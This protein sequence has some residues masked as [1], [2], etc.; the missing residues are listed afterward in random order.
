MPGNRPADIKV[1]IF[2][3]GIAGM[4]VAHELIERGFKV[5]LVDKEKNEVLEGAD[6]VVPIRCGGMAAT[7][8]CY[9][10]RGDGIPTNIPL[11]R[12]YSS[13]EL[14]LRPRV[15]FDPDSVQPRD[16]GEITTKVNAVIEELL[17][18]FPRLVVPHAHAPRHFPTV[19]TSGHD[20]RGDVNR[21]EKRAM[22][23]AKALDEAGVASDFMVSQRNLTDGDYVDFW[24]D[25]YTL[26]GEHGFR[27]F[28]SF[29]RNLFDTMKRTPIPGFID[30]AVAMSVGK[31]P[32]GGRRHYEKG[33]NVYENLVP[34]GALQLTFDQPKKN[35]TVDRARPK[36]FKQ[37]RQ[38]LHSFMT[39]LGATLE[40][41]E[42]ME[43]KLFI[44]MTSCPERRGWYENMSWYQF[45][46]GERYSPR[47]RNYLQ[48]SSQALGALRGSE[49]DARTYGNTVVQLLLDH[50]TVGEHSDATLSGP[51]S[52]AWFD[53]WHR[54]LDDQGVE[55]AVDELRGF[56]V[57][58][59][60]VLP[61]TSRG[62]NYGNANY[63]VLATDLPTARKLAPW[64]LKAAQAAGAVGNDLQDFKRLVDWL[65]THWWRDY[66]KADPR[67]PLRHLSGIQFFF[68]AN[69]YFE[70][71]HT[72][73]LD[74]P[75]GL[76]CISQP[77]FWFQPKS[78]EQ[79]FQGL[80]SVDIADWSRPFAGVGHR[81]A[82]ELGLDEIARG[83]W[84][85]IKTSLQT[86]D[87]LPDPT[88]FHLDYNVS[89]D[90][91]KRR[92]A[93]PFLIPLAGDYRHRPGDPD[94][95]RCHHAPGSASGG[96]LVAANF[97]KTHTRLTTME[98]PN[99]SARHAVNA[100][101][102]DAQVASER[103]RV[104]NPEENE[105]ADL[106]EWIELDQRLFKKGA[107]HAAILSGW[108]RLPDLTVPRLDLI[109][110]LALRGGG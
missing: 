99:E 24:V 18:R 101:L 32:I 42:R 77:Q 8:W 97:M 14:N 93:T 74:A 86:R 61:K 2:G 53:H 66:T 52:S 36:S 75:W 28:P 56:T 96:W 80:I 70:H 87:E 10:P 88:F 81:C 19:F 91:V 15:E 50:L 103:C 3:A 26:P 13:A 43:I 108:K 60:R 16:A 27:F 41:I 102:D 35:F 9:S 34:T 1:V 76:S 17:N 59:G 11:A 40:D 82:W 51:T 30:P 58:Q 79:P 44:Y 21:A 57:Q 73:F 90:P 98:A 46:E 106:C 109:G 83:T 48:S 92:N 100:L 95:Y 67:G 63:F 84:N 89:V 62:T 107:P 20:S 104:F 55:F 72:L 38:V 78:E 49:A 25:R 110:L 94:R 29:Y 7:Q 6:G 4:T 85:Q 22:L 105:L 68:D 23:V 45:V 69:L 54:Y 12:T 71:A 47:F 33:T 39:S 65:P 31:L 64:Y 5:T 37:M